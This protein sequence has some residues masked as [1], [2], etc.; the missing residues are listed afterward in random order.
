MGRMYLLILGFV[1]GLALYFACFKKGILRRNLVEVFSK[2]ISEY[3]RISLLFILSREIHT[4]FI[5]SRLLIASKIHTIIG[6]VCL[7]GNRFPGL[8]KTKIL[9]FELIV[10]GHLLVSYV[11]LFFSLYIVS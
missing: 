1:L 3:V 11:S 10:F 7:Y 9:I 6:Y 4:R 2:K 8:S 5:Y